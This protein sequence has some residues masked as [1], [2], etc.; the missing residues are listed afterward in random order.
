MRRGRSSSCV[1]AALFAFGFVFSSGETSAQGPIQFT[2]SRIISLSTGA[3][4]QA[5]ANLLGSPHEELIWGSGINVTI[6]DTHVVGAPS[7]TTVAVFPANAFTSFVKDVISGDINNDG[8]IDLVARTNSAQLKVIKNLGGGS[9]SVASLPTSSVQRV[10]LA[11]FSGDGFLD[12]L[13]GGQRWTNDGTGAFPTSIVFS[14]GT[15]ATPIDV[16]PG[17]F[18]GDGDQDFVSVYSATIP[19]GTGIIARIFRQNASGTFTQL[20]ASLLDPATSGFADVADFNQDGKDDLL[21]TAT[22]TSPY[23]GDS[24]ISFRTFLGQ[25]GPSLMPQASTEVG[26]TAEKAPIIADWNGDGF[27]DIATFVRT[28]RGTLTLATETG[29]GFLVNDGTGVFEPAAGPGLYDLSGLG[30]SIFAGS[31]TACV[32]DDNLDG[33]KDLVLAPGGPIVVYGNDSATAL[34]VATQVTNP[35]AGKIVARSI[36]GSITFD[37][38]ISGASSLVPAAGHFVMAD[39]VAPDGTPR[40]LTT[41]TSSTG[42]VKFALPTGFPTSAIPI[43]IST[44]EGTL[45][46][47]TLLTQVSLNVGAGAN[48]S[49]YS[50]MPFAPSTGQLLDSGSAPIE[51]VRVYARTIPGAPTFVTFG[52]AVT[53]SG[54]NFS[55]SAVAGIPGTT[56]CEFFV[57]EAFHSASFSMT[58]LLVTNLITVTQGAGQLACAGV[59]IVPIVGVVQTPFGSPVPGLTLT[60]APT[61]ATGLAPVTFDSTTIVTDMFGGFTFTGVG[62]PVVTT[63]S[64]IITGSGNTTPTS[65]NLS[66]Q[67]AVT[68]TVVAGQ[69]QAIELGE[70]LPAPFV[71]TVTDCFGAPVV[72]TSV[73]LVPQTSGVTVSQTTLTTDAMGEVSFTPTYTDIGAQRVRLSVGSSS[74]DAVAIVRGLAATN[75]GFLLAISFQHEHADVPLLLAV[76]TPPAS[77]YLSTPYGDIWTTILAPQ[78]TL[79]YLDGF[80]LF[81]SIDPGM[82]TGPQGTWVR[83]YLLQP[84]FYNVTFIAQMY[85][86][87][88]LNV[89]PDDY[90]VSNPA[91]FTL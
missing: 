64:Y 54:G 71:V 36:A 21:L 11:D 18:D 5:S 31:F 28:A 79:F 75:I 49:A 19:A 91:F 33:A 20:V 63:R 65:F 78:P 86:Y 55:I 30:S 59:P 9:F 69:S 76:D 39:F 24:T 53:D 84:E 4:Q 7:V 89:F 80:G 51:G 72:G 15:T 81:G 77:P 61:A 90:I 32:T 60:I 47:F 48:Q 27:L 44:P 58:S 67:M 46:N 88:A 70:A 2:P 22:D 57:P 66:S 85:G 50:G 68:L 16:I 10:H 23:P 74:V 73:T 35:S 26:V 13:C 45:G 8:L 43:V 42:Q 37:L 14:S 52:S 82:V 83:T 38:T 34:P 25:A 6:L 29:I 56:T 62:N 17:D 40:R 1:M 3:V 12:I 87:A 41:L